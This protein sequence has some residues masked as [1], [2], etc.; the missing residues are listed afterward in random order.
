MSAPREAF[1]A[2]LRAGLRGL[3]GH[4]IEETLADYTR[5]FDEGNAVRRSDADIAAALGDPLELAAAIR[6]ET[7]VAD[8]RTT[9]TAR[10]GLA[11][12][13]GVAARVGLG[14]ALLPLG[15]LLT[16][17]LASLFGVMLVLSGA[18]LWLLLDGGSLGLAGGTLT[19]LLAGIG[20]IAA[21]ISLVAMTLLAFASIITTLGERALA[22]LK[23][24]KATST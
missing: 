9:P 15:F 1:L 16:L 14:L 7:Q 22:R 11:L 4:D 13:R 20:L 5:H 24:N 10:S 2:T 18:G 12:L 17:F 19:T 3:A 6:L 23:S 8:W 21:A